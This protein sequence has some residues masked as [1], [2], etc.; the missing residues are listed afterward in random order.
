MLF[1]SFGLFLKQQENYFLSNTN[2]NPCI[3][4]IDKQNCVM[5]LIINA[6]DQT[7]KG[8]EPSDFELSF[9]LVQ[10]V[11]ELRTE[12]DSYVIFPQLETDRKR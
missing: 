11:Y 4:S 8:K 2:T 3:H 12:R 6:I 9:E 1:I 7:V 5:A 10:N